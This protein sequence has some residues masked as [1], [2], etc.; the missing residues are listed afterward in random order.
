MH[1]YGEEISVDATEKDPEELE[2]SQGSLL[3]LVLLFA[4]TRIGSDAGICLVSI[5]PS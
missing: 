3:D 1:L 2:V 5:M 4:L